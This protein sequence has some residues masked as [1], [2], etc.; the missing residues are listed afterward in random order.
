[1]AIDSTV[2]TSKLQLKYNYGIDGNGNNII[3]SKTYSNVKTDVADQSIYDVA[4]A[5]SALQSNT[6]EG[7]H[8]VQDIILVEV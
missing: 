3:K 4:S 8:K 6:L 5:I 1:M 2:N 7:I